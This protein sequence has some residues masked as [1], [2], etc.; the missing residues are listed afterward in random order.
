MKIMIDDYE[1][2]IKAK[3][4]GNGLHDED[5]MNKEDTLSA[6][7]Q[8]VI[9]LGE[10]KERYAELGLNALGK[11]ATENYRKLVNVLDAKGYFKQ[12]GM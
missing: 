2:E 7:A 9:W 8:I 4:N 1:V 10:A 11:R 6:I 3:W 12:F 5:R